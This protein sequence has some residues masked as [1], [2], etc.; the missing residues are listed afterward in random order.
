MR[1]DDAQRRASR[2]QAGHRERAEQD[3]PVTASR[4]WRGAAA[5]VVAG[6]AGLLAGAAAAHAAIVAV[7]PY[8][9]PPGMPRE[10]SCLV[11]CDEPTLWVRA[12]PGE[13]NLI[14]IVSDATEVVVL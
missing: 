10:E 13:R 14:T 11:R 7:G 6:A 1:R 8:A 12:E 5:A 2:A 3:R 9:D 4:L